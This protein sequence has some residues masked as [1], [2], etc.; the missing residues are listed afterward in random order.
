MAIRQPTNFPRVEVKARI[1]TDLHKRLVDECGICACHI[2]GFIAIAIAHEVARRRKDRK[3]EAD[4]YID[5]MTIE[6]ESIF[7]A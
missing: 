4:K 5:D 3:E 2:N 6:A 1:S 7:N